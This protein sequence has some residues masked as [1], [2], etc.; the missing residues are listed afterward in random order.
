[1]G[2]LV[3][4][5]LFLFVI[6]QYVRYKTVTNLQVLFPLFWFLICFFGNLGIGDSYTPSDFAYIYILVSVAFFCIGGRIISSFSIK[7]IDYENKSENVKWHRVI[8]FW[9][10]LTIGIIISLKQLILLAPVIL[11]YGVGV[12]RNMLQ[13]NPNLQLE[14][15]VYILYLYL[16]KPIIRAGIIIYIIKL[17]FEKLSVKNASVVMFLTILS[18][19]S[20]GNRLTILYVIIAIAF[21]IFDKKIVLSKKVKRYL[22][23]AL[24]AAVFLIIY[25]T[26]E[27]GG[28]A[29]GNIY[30]Y[31]CESTIYFS[32]Y[33]EKYIK[34]S[35]L[36][37]GVVS[38]QG[39]LKPIFGVLANVTG[40]SQ[41]S[42]MTDCDD[43]LDSLQST[44]IMTSPSGG[45]NY[46]LT[47]FGYFAKDFGYFGA[48]IV[49]FIYGQ[50]C[51][52]IEKYRKKHEKNLKI[53]CFEILFVQGVLTSMYMFPFADINTVMCGVY[54]FLFTT[55]TDRR[56]LKVKV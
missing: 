20:D 19:V 34:G 13:A 48:V 4:L 30:S 47:C 50:I 5:I 51:A 29:L 27:R 26:H 1:M 16:S 37:L 33:Y 12:A 21:I 52:G 45:M 2:F 23:I 55:N 38:F 8:G 40:M 39:F 35:Q 18:Y 10:L 22:N 9:I 28:S 42:F 17:F 3:S 46:Y 11:K 44:V 31:F 49:P 25:A 56:S 14:T 53:L 15:N 43:F 54:I 32:G 41:P 24:V 7:T 6:L 36:T